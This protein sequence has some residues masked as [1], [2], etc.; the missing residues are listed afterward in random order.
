[1]IKIKPL[2]KLYNSGTTLPGTM[3]TVKV[4]NSKLYQLE[5][6]Y[7]EA[8]EALFSFTL[9]N[10]K[11]LESINVT[12]MDDQIAEHIH[13]IEIIEKATGKSWEELKE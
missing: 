11:L 3:E 13:R 1:M 9:N 8:I 4:N 7:Q 12:L 6:N 10:A 2:E 5:A